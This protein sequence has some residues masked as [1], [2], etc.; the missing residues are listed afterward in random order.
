MAPSSDALPEPTP[1]RSRRRRALIWGGGG[2]LAM[3]AVAALVIGIARPD[4]YVRAWDA[5][6]ITC[7]RNL[8]SMD[9]GTFDSPWAAWGE[10][11][12]SGVD[13][14]E[15]DT[16]RERIEQLADELGF[17]PVGEIPSTTDYSD[18]EVSA[19]E[20]SV[21][22]EA[23]G[24]QL[25]LGVNET[26]GLRRLALIDPGTGEASWQWNLD[27]SRDAGVI[28]QGEH[29][30]LVNRIL[31]GQNVFVGEQSTE[32]LSLGRDTGEREYCRRFPGSGG[33]AA[34]TTDAGLL[35][36]GKSWNPMVADEEQDDIDT[37]TV[38]QV[39]LPRFSPGF[40]TTFEAIEYEKDGFPRTR[41]LPLSMG[42]EGIFLT[43]A[44]GLG[45]LT[46]D[47]L[48]TVSTRTDTVRDPDLIPIAA[49]SLETGEVLWEYGS[50]GDPIAVVDRVASGANGE[51]D[52]ILI[53]E[54]SDF[55]PRSDDPDLGSAA[56]TVRLLDSEG[57]EVWEA[58]GTEVGEEFSSGDAD[59]YVK[60][61]GDVVL[62]HTGPTEVT[63]FDAYTGEEL[64]SI[65]GS[66]DQMQ[67]L[68]LGDAVT[69]DGQL[70]VPGYER[71]YFVDPRTGA[72]APETATAIARAQVLDIR[73]LG[74]DF[75]WVGTERTGTVVLQRA[76]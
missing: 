61:L 15:V 37:R 42:P 56:V 20:V 40:T 39:T 46:P 7:G 68:W 49:R 29:L 73:S 58:A 3:V 64:W 43:H 28:E 35:V 36:G 55:R 65:P 18:G 17:V 52:G 44:Y 1:R 57:Q 11:E 47:D 53:A 10:A 2:I 26:Q 23:Q 62:L 75:I 5:S 45:S 71:Q 4:W 32:L 12:H 66:P 6:G 72:D 16:H 69:L 13:A 33:Y 60:V 41:S 59:R 24:D 76:S 54:T 63:A 8:S 22:V 67:P 70:Y 31:R 27:E 9:A 51:D 14:A 30:V 50:P 48:F 21:E 74:E 19:D 38:Q 25:R 34:S